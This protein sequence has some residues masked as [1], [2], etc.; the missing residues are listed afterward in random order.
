[1]ASNKVLKVALGK[2]EV[3]EQAEGL[4][5]LSEHVSGNVGLFFT[6][7]P[8]REVEQLFSTFQVLARGQRQDA[9]W[10]CLHAVDGCFVRVF[11]ASGLDTRWF[12]T[13]C[14]LCMCRL[15]ILHGQAAGPLRISL[16]RKVLWR[17]RS[18]R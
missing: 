11:R 3:D 6:T 17:A 1:M 14:R 10:P 2:S 13:P 7:L 12:R 9:T 15:W 8:R 18:V 16:S 5:R 4:H